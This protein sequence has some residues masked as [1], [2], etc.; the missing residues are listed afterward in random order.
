MKL[1]IPEEEVIEETSKACED[2]EAEEAEA[3]VEEKAEETASVQ[4]AEEN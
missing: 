2:A 3:Q 4:E 1:D